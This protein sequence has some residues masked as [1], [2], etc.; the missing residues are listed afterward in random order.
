MLHNAIHDAI[1]GIDTFMITLQAFPSFISGY[2][3]CDAVFGAEFLELG[4]YAGGDDRDAFCVE[5]IHHRFEEGQ[6][7][8]DC[9][10]EE[11]R[12]AVE[13]ESVSIDCFIVYVRAGWKGNTNTRTEYG[14]TKAVLCWKKSAEDTWGTSRTTSVPFSAFLPS[15]SPLFWFFLSRASFCPIMRLTWDERMLECGVASN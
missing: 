15:I 12:V 9:V 14:G 11:V 10:G 4:H 6:F 1:I 13:K 2:A 8:L 5:G 3:K 7:A